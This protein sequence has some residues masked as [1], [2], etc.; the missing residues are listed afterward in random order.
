MDNLLYK[1]AREKWVDVLKGLLIILVVLGHSI[2]ALGASDNYSKSILIAIYTVHMPLFFILSGYVYVPKNVTLVNYI[3]AKLKRLMFPYLI[4][5]IVNTIFDIAFGRCSIKSFFAEL[6]TNWFHILF[7]TTKSVFS[8]LWF[9]PTLTFALII[10]S[11][12]EKKIKGNL[13]RFLISIMLVFFSQIWYLMKMDSVLGIREAMIAQFFVLVGFYVKNFLNGIDRRSTMRLFGISLVI[14]GYGIAEWIHFG[15][16]TVNYW[17]SDIA[18]I[19]WTLPLALFGDMTFITFIKLWDYKQGFCY[20]NILNYLGVNSLYIYGLHYSFLR[21]L[22][23]F[24]PEGMNIKLQILIN[25][26]FTLFCTIFLLEIYRV[27]KKKFCEFI[28]KLWG[29]K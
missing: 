27:I 2:S 18:P 16:F 22:I 4:F 21:V 10:F 26:L 13:N 19:T 14:W 8:S 23:Q 12:I 6:G 1:Q 5:A 3:F 15:N 7:M 17:N 24:Y 28:M 29:H 9:L 25:T 20:N 11:I